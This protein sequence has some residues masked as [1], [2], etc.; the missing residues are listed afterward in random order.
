M[1]QKTIEGSKNR[2]LNRVHW[3]D[4]AA[5]A[6]ERFDMRIEALERGESI[7]DPKYR[8]LFP[9]EEKARKGSEKGE[10]MEDGPSRAD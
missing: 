9:E 5:S 10:T 4:S 1:G 6:L 7:I 8:S 2:D 3:I